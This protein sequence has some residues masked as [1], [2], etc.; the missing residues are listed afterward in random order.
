MPQ[1]TTKINEKDKSKKRLGGAKAGTHAMEFNNYI[2]DFFGLIIIIMIVLVLAG[3]FFLFGK[4]RFQQA[5]FHVAD[6][7][8]QLEDEKR[9]L[10]KYR[11]KI[12]SYKDSYAIIGI[13]DRKK[14]DDM[15]GPYQNYPSVYQ[16]DLVI[17]FRELFRDK[18]YKLI[19]LKI[20]EEGAKN[21]VVSR[22]KKT[23]K[24]ENDTESRNLPHDITIINLTLKI[25]N[26]SY[27]GLKDL[28]ALLERKLR[29][30]DVLS[31]KYSPEGQTCSLSLATYQFSK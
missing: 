30:T 19:D 1:V 14:V 4:P 12:I 23:T 20:S 28:L 17:N 6:A 2:D 13:D 15:I 16:T 10:E 31:V 8:S 26:V 27:D 24:T 7:K 3:A 22:K 29:L 25:E 11:D 18:K 5:K 21:K 9:Q